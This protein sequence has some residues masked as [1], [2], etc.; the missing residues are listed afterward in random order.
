[1]EHH[2]DGESRRCSA[3]GRLILHLVLFSSL[4]ARLPRLQP[5]RREDLFER[6]P[7]G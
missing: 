7:A 3:V 4:A 2:R 1:M 5:R 6:Q